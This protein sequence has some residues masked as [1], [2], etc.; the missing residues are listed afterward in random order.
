MFLFQNK[1]Y[2]TMHEEAECKE[3]IYKKYIISILKFFSQHG[4]IEDHEAM[5]MEFWW[6]MAVKQESNSEIR[7]KKEKDIIKHEK[8]QKLLQPNVFSGKKFCECN[9]L[10]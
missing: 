9:N 1:G 8:S 2:K 5:S 10:K 4:M 6:K 7:G 3:V